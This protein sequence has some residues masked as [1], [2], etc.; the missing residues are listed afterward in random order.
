M[1]TLK[2][3]KEPPR[4][5]A[6]EIES[7]I[8]WCVANQA[9]DITI[10]NE[11]QVVCDIHGKKIRVTKRRLTK[12]EV[13]EIITAI[14][15]GEGAVSVLNGGEPVDMPWSIK[16]SRD[17]TIRFRINMISI[18]AENHKGYQITIRVINNTPIDFKLL[19]LP[20]EIV[21]NF[22]PKMGIVLV[23]GATGSGKSTLLSSMLANVMSKE[24]SNLK[25]ITYEDPVEFVY[26]NVPKPSTSVAQSQIG[27]HVHDFKVALKVALRRKPD[28]IL[29]GEMR[30]RET[31]ERAIEASPTGHLVLS[32]LHVNGVAETIRRVVNA[33]DPGEQNAKANDILTSLKLIVAQMLVPSSDGKRIAIRE[34]LVFNEEIGEQIIDGGLDNITFTTKKLIKK[35]GKTFY[36]DLKEK[37]DQNLIT[38]KTFNEIKS[39]LR[40][41]DEDANVMLKENNLS[42]PEDGNWRPVG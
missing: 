37:F 27:E 6:S 12:S 30:D 23:V 36:Q 41:R 22:T 18:L 16:V 39:S 5:G 34:H 24:D 38:E 33:F 26:D 13:I 31:I 9:S 19:N 17:E 32:T 8:L 21:D 2:Y 35:H 10:Q 3:D 20:A 40:V 28:I 4:M 14:Y 42:E 7:F 29:I 11:D 1:T 25:I 15:K